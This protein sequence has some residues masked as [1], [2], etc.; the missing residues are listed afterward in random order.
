MAQQKFSRE[1]L[2]K[3]PEFAG[4]QRDFLGAVLAEPFYTMAKAR[5]AVEEFFGV[6]KG[7]DE[8]GRREGELAE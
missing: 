2:L 7:E 1:A 3:A 5:K 4:Y 8:N 6:K